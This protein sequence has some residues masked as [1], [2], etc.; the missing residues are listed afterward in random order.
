[1]DKGAATA[2]GGTPAPRGVKCWHT[3]LWLYAGL[4]VFNNP[5]WL[6]MP[7]KGLNCLATDLSSLCL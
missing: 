6:K 4:I 5:C 2:E 1:M 7:Q 3:D